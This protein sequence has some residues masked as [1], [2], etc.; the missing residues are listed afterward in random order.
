MRDKPEPVSVPGGQSAQGE[1]IADHKQH[2]T[3]PRQQSVLV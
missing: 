3:F 1:A 2:K